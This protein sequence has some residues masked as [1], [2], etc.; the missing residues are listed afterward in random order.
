MEP[1]PTPVM[2]AFLSLNVV[3]DV[4]TSRQVRAVLPLGAHTTLEIEDLASRYGGNA[5]NLR[6]KN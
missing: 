6:P 5:G 2:R 1:F 3:P 4:A